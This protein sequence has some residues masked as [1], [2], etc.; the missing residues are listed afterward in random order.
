MDKTNLFSIG[1]IAKLFSLSVGSL[2]HYENL[3]ILKPEYIDEKTGQRL[4]AER[5]DG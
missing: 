2:R 4:I 1:N 3:G 5:L